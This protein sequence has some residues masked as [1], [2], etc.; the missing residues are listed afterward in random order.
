MADCGVTEIPPSE[1]IRKLSPHEALDRTDE[2][3]EARYA[4][5]GLGNKE[6]PLDEL[7]YIQLSVQ[8]QEVGFNR[9]YDD[10]RRAF[11]TWR[12]V[13][14][15]PTA[16]LI[17][18]L[19]PAG[20]SRQKTPRLKAILR[21]ALRDAKAAAQANGIGPNKVREPSLSFLS[22]LSD[23][24][25]ERYLLAL[26]GVGPKTARCVLM[27]S[28]RRAVF[29]VD[30][31]VYRILTR[32]GIVERLPWKKA[33]DPYQTFVPPAVRYR[34]HVNFVHHGRQV[35]TPLRPNCSQ[36]VLVSFCKTGIEEHRRK[37]K[38][39]PIAIDLF[40]GAGILSAG[41]RTTG[42]DIVFAAETNRNAA[43]TYRYN[44]PG[45][46]V[47]ETDVQRLRATDVLSTVGLCKGRL[48]AVIGGPPCQ[49]YSAAGKRLPRAPRNYLYRSFGTLARKLGAQLVM[50]ENVPGVRQVNGTRFVRKILR[51]FRRLGYVSNSF[52]LNAIGYGV[53]QKR[54]RFI[55]VGI[56]KRV[57]VEPSCPPPQYA[58][59]GQRHRR[60]PRPPTIRNVLSGL[61][62]VESARG[63][64]VEQPNGNLIFNHWAMRHCSRVISKIRRI[65]PGKGPISYKRLTWKYSG[66]IVAG[67]RALPVHP[68]IARTIT[69]REAARIQTIPDCYRF[70]GPRSEQPIQ[71]ADAVPYKVAQALGK[72]MLS[73][74]PSKGSTV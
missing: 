17:R 40:S 1:M 32:L 33:H 3:L 74:V 71:V 18:I 73:I 6:D 24:E 70:L 14:D 7:I 26:P 64:E 42:W 19:K 35:C 57:G 12:A 53:P 55:F 72:H 45:I 56:A 44:N 21:I 50:M 66:T 29:P 48:D 61:P 4:S 20:L 69:V 22:K 46:P 38:K 34:L 43:Q 60:L 65:Q 15:A 13:L 16:R 67:H 62:S 68:G 10:L 58:D 5:K 39:G 28:L 63:L 51:H 49:D 9:S 27:Y 47:F 11:P 41:F 30:V 31:N 36:C 25:A 59:P 2:L 54:K 23:D 52:L 37:P 8:T